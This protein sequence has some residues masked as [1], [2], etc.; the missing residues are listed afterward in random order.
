MFIRR[1]RIGPNE[2]KAKI[3]KVITLLCWDNQIWSSIAE[4][5][6]MIKN[7]QAVSMRQVPLGSVSSRS[8]HKRYGP[9]GTKAVPS[10]GYRTWSC[11]RVTQVAPVLKA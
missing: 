5:S 11:V 10:V 9:E 2:Q 8:A 7:I 6:D 4:D 3:T 1:S